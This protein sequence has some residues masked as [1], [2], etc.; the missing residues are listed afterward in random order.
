VARAAGVISAAT[1][2]SRLLGL[3][4]EQVFAIQFGAGYAVD[5]FQVAFRIPNLLRDLFA[6]G[7]MNAAFVPTLS[8][9][10]HRGGPQA[11]LRLANLVINLLLIVIS[12]ICLVG[13]LTAPWIV[14]VM[15]PGFADEAGKV[16]LTTL[17]TQI[18]MPYLLFVSLAAAAMGFLNTRRVFFI[19]ALSPTMLNVGLIAAGFLLAPVMPRFGLEP[20][21]GMA[22]GALLGGIG[23]LAIQIPSMRAQGFQWRPIVSFRDPDVLRMVS[24]MA[25]AAVGIAAADVNVFVST[26]LASTLAEGSVSWLNYAY[27]LMQLPIGLFGVAV[28]TVTLA[29][30]ARHAA[31]KNMAD[32]KETLSFSLGLV[33]FLTVPATLALVVLARPIVSLLYEH[34]RF[35]SADT[36][37]TARALWGY[38]VGLAAFSAVR[39]MVPAFYSLGLARIPVTVA[40][41]SIGATVVLYFVLMGPF[42]H[43][44]LA[45]A[46]SLGSVMNFTVLAWMLRRRIG[47]IG[48]RSLASSAVKIL[49]AGGLAAALAWIVAG[50][51]ES[52][53]GLRSVFGRLLVVF[54]G[55]AVGAFTYFIAGRALRIRELEAIASRVGRR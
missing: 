39:V 33:L 43:A 55:L 35:T 2:V 48:G 40:I 5:A 25:P 16:A 21:V 46:T 29:E 52:V 19:P 41:A 37:Q 17:L 51:L 6:E 24:L 42:Q 22:A 34:G 8:Q 10:Q 31:A 47:G 36:L 27:R 44:G 15:A 4:R 20:I 38:A 18:M 9:A 23:Q 7:A 30:V 54:T 45:L 32:L 11:A 53:I 14:R 3:V 26:F 1:F 49:A 13:V 50:Q 28:A 12:L